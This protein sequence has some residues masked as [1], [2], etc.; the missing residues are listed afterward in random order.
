MRS[1]WSWLPDS[2]AVAFAKWLDSVVNHCSSAPIEVDV[3]QVL[4]LVRESLALWISLFL[5]PLPKNL[6]NGRAL[7]RKY[8]NKDFSSNIYGLRSVYKNLKTLFKI[9]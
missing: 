9:R 4:I 3:E 8:W 7:R 1:E 5:S 2:E 6:S